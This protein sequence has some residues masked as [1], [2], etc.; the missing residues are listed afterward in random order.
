MLALVGTR[1]GENIMPLLQAMLEM[2]LNLILKMEDS[3]QSIPI[4][5]LG[6]S[7]AD[8]KCMKII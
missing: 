3:T 8:Y 5:K 4:L 7:T 1:Q 2:N 6:D